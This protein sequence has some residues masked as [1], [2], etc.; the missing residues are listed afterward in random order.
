MVFNHQPAGP[1][2]KDT[3]SEHWMVHGKSSTKMDEKW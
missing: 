3:P 2:I 1:E